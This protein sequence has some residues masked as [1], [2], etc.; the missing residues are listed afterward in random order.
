MGA[1]DPGDR[2]LFWIF[3]RVGFSGHQPVPLC[4]ADSEPLIHAVSTLTSS[5]FS[6]INTRDLCMTRAGDG[7]TLRCHSPSQ[8]VVVCGTSRPSDAALLA[9][10]QRCPDAREAASMASIVTTLTAAVQRCSST[11]GRP[12]GPPGA[13]VY[14][15]SFTHR[16]GPDRCCLQRRSVGR[17]RLS[18][19]RNTTTWYELPSSP[20]PSPSCLHCT[21]QVPPWTTLAT[22]GVLPAPHGLEVA[23]V[24][25]RPRCPPS[26]RLPQWPLPSQPVR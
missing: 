15:A 19:P 17:G 10:G 26:A 6:S 1:A 20:L 5:G 12:L 2:R 9:R 22:P 8:L 13:T 18:Q 14:S 21:K 25:R 7:S 16:C 11:A 23:H 24:P 3:G 4:C